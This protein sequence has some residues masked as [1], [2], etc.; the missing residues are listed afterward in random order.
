MRTLN[1]N[2]IPLSISQQE[3][4][5]NSFIPLRLKMTRGY[6]V[7]FYNFNGDIMEVAEGVDVL[8]SNFE[9]ERLDTEE[10]I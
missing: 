5:L 9:Y 10:G 7:T 8:V 2:P 1:I 6:V 3:H 4:H